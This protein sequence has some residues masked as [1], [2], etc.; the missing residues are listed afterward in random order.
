M[1]TSFDFKI[2]YVEAN[3]EHLLK[4]KWNFL[5]LIIKCHI[6]RQIMSIYWYQSDFFFFK[7]KIYCYWVEWVL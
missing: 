6:W 7:F 4:S 2:S 1:R 5:V 3:Y